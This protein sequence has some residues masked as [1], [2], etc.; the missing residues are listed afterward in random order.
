MTDKAI[1]NLTVEDAIRA[2]Y[3]KQKT[4]DWN[5]VANKADPRSWEGWYSS[6]HTLNDFANQYGPQIA[7]AARQAWKGGT[8]ELLRN[9]PGTGLTQGMTRTIGG[10]TYVN[11]TGKP[12]GWHEQQ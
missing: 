5:M 4:N 2:A 11:L 12:D 8:A 3:N 7:Q 10:K 9:A 1:Y 6:A